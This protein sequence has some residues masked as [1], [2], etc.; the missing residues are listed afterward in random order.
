M[1]I[2]YANLRY[3]ILFVYIETLRDGDMTNWYGGTTFSFQKPPVKNL[4]E[5]VSVIKV[6]NKT[7]QCYKHL[8]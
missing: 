3:F 2:V 4:G 7:D 8:H 1:H 6:N 5:E